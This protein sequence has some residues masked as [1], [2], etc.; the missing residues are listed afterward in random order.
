MKYNQSDLM[1]EA[2]NQHIF[3]NSHEQEITNHLNN[4]FKGVAELFRNVNNLR[5]SFNEEQ[6]W[7][8]YELCI[9]YGIAIHKYIKT[10]EVITEDI[11]NVKNAVINLRKIKSIGLDKAKKFKMLK[12]FTYIFQFMQK[13]RN[14][15]IKA[16]KE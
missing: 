7:V 14:E 11:T 4:D 15:I 3:L 2:L 5:Q 13:H 6:F 16:I 9:N 1:K 12:Y 8:T 10:I